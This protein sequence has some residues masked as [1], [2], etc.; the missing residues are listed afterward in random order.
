MMNILS[1]Y[2]WAACTSWMPATNCTQDAWVQSI[3]SRVW[4]RY[5]THLEPSVDISRIEISVKDIGSDVSY[6]T[7]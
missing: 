6:C 5:C 1:R 3:Q 2:V 4:S 7:L